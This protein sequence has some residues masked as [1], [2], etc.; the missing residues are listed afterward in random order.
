MYR[1]L[2]DDGRGAEILRR[3]VCSK[4]S[5]EKASKVGLNGRCKKNVI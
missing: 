3:A 4:G 2:K 5:T 1:E